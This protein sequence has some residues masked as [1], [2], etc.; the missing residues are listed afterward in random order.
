MPT[1]P[2]TPNPDQGK[3]DHRAGLQ[4]S[5][6]Q[7]MLSALDSETLGVRRAAFAFVVGV[8]SKDEIAHFAYSTK[9]G[10]TLIETCQA[11]ARVQ[12]E[13]HA[14]V[15]KLAQQSGCEEAYVQGIVMRLMDAATPTTNAPTQ[16]GGAA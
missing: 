16:E 2:N 3:P 1:T 6:T 11:L 15:K 13:V 8:G 7:V 12:L 10:G 4:V 14:V 9:D 5:L